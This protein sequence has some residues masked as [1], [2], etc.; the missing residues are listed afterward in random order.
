M[1]NS[2]YINYNAGNIIYIRLRRKTFGRTIQQLRDYLHT[3]PLTFVFPGNAEHISIA[4]TGTLAGLF[5][6]NILYSTAAKTFDVGKSTLI[7]IIQQKVS[8]R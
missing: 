4:G 8:F 2:Y 6:K 3:H 7:K 1:E 5:E